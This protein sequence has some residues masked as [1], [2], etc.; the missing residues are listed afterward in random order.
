MWLDS[1]VVLMVSVTWMLVL[2]CV[3]AVHCE[4]IGELYYP[5]TVCQ[6]G[7]KTELS[8][9]EG[10]CKFTY[11]KEQAHWWRSRVLT[12]QQLHSYV[13]C[14]IYMTNLSFDTSQCQ[15]PSTYCDIAD[16]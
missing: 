15:C 12:K 2:G 4:S 10:S 11:I 14:L 5:M 8:A 3:E 16:E 9:L 1:V 13:L 6:T 7:N